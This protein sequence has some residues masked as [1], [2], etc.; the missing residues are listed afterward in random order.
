MK[1]LLITLILFVRIVAS[2]QNSFQPKKET[3]DA[4]QRISFLTGTW[5]GSGW[6]QMGPQKNTFTQTETISSKVNG[7]VIQIDG[8]G[9]DQQKSDVIIHQAFAIISYDVENSKYLMKAFRGDGGQI[10][11]N[12]KLLDDHTFEW[13][14]S[15]AMTGQIKFTITVV[16]NRWTEIGE[17]SR[18]NGKNWYKYFE[19]VLDKQ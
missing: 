14:F 15:T 18:D 16:N 17:M 4:I 6:I 3:T 13:R 19:M 9:K 5:K 12:A 10:D 8:Q 11:A 7:T 1:Q 2:A